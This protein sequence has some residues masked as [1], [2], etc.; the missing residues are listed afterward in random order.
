MQ[1]I[2]DE[3][4]K[5]ILE[6]FPKD[7]SAFLASLNNTPVA[8]IRLNKS[9]C[10]ELFI[11]S[12]QVP[13]NREG[14][15]LRERPR[16]TLDPT[17]HAGCYYPQESSSMALQWVLEHVIP[18]NTPI[19][20]LD[21]CAAPGGKSL[22]ISDFLS[23]RDGVEGRLISN[24]IIRS[25]AHI[26]TEVLTKWG[27]HNVAV[28][29]NK[30][31]D[32]AAC[33]M[34]FDLI[35]VDAPCSGE[36]M[37]RKDPQARE[38]WSTESVNMCSRR[39]KDILT[40]IL[41]ALKENGVLIYSTCT[42][43]VDENE[44]QI[45]ELVATG[46]FESIRWPVPSN[47]NV[48]VIDESRVFAMR[49]LPHK[50]SGEGFFIAALRKTS[51]DSL[52]RN[53]PKSLFARPSRNEE[54]AI[55]KCGIP[56]DEIVLAPN[57]ELYQSPFSDRELN[58]LASSLYFLS[59]GTHLG[60]IL[61]AELIPAHA[62]ALAP[63]IETNYSTLELSREQ[64]LT[65]LRGDTISTNASPGWQRVAYNGCVLGWIKVIGNRINNYYPKEWRVKLKE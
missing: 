34:Q 3:F 54:M 2:P 40:D 56:A 6:Q 53:K 42:F 5:R 9:K 32:F 25:R 46:E 43:A 62:M 60:K 15:I 4:C 18:A 38:E 58:S 23:N 20:A 19:D 55:L 8:S 1:A 7:G 64:A 39:Q 37:F 30:P 13:W 21:L 57:G 16:Y 50:V 33:G 51:S 12:E 27:A 63:H 28:T 29:N 52:R 11:G 41:P 17:F 48:D 14:R 22:I 31:A 36:G 45:A 26:L 47:W 49:F 35:V 61:H 65:Y 44:N 24:E 10:G 59:P